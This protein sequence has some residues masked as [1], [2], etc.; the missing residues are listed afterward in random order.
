[1][2]RCYIELQN[3][4][5][6]PQPSDHSA[7]RL[8]R[9]WNRVA[10]R[11]FDVVAATLLLIP[12]IPIGAII[13]VAIAIE[14]PGPVFFV[15]DR[16]GRFGRRFRLWK[17]RSMV[18]NADE[19][20]SRYF[21][22]HPGS[23]KEWEQTHK[24]KND[25]RVTCVGRVLRRT[26]LDELPQLLSVIRGDMSMIGPRPIV[27]SEL[28]KYGAAFDLYTQVRPGLTGLWQ[29][30]G[31]TDTSYRERIALDTAYIQNWSFCTDLMILLKTVRVVLFGH[32]AY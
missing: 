21:Q 3:R 8:F 24:L 20:L 6:M 27:E 2:L 17:L 16:I 5:F 12:A 28:G 30:S 7:C 26:S 13:A 10:K 31:R 15:H 19:A 1:M 18:P 11:I 23:A 25:P 22:S 32:G 29:V 4:R 9:K 14:S